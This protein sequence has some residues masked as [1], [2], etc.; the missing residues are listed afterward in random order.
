MKMF[1]ISILALLSSILLFTTGC[2]RTTNLSIVSFK[3]PAFSNNIY[4]NVCI[5]VN[6]AD[7]HQR[8]IMERTFTAKFRES[9]IN[10]ISSIDM[11]TPTRE[12]STESTFE[13]LERSNI[14]GF[15]VLEIEDVRRE[16]VYVPGKTVV[17]TKKTSSTEKSKDTAKTGGK[18]ERTETT[19]VTEEPPRTY[20]NTLCTVSIKFYDVKTGKT[21]WI[22]SIKAEDGRGVN[23]LSLN[24]RGYL[25]DFALDLL[26]ALYK[27]RIIIIKES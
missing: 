18:R 26:S 27:D 5:N 24:N 3:D 21:S 12:W 7:L 11:L 10:T 13:A 15:L 6:V 2:F 20:E 25:E 9:G 16:T 8:T 22:A 17:E 19:V 1:K 4:K 14:D 23:M